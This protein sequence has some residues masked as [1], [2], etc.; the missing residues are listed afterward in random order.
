MIIRIVFASLDGPTRNE[1]KTSL[2]MNL[3]IIL[4]GILHNWSIQPFSQD[5]NLASHIIYVV[6]VKFIHEWRALQ[7]N[8]DYE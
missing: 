5:Y 8:V 4:V 1:K 7:F 2:R 6:C 3:I